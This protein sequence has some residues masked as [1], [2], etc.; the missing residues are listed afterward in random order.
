MAQAQQQDLIQLDIVDEKTVNLWRSIG[1][2][3]KTGGRSKM[4]R[5]RTSSS[6]VALMRSV[7][8]SVQ[9][10]KIDSRRSFFLPSTSL[11]PA[12]SL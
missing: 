10:P 12:A 6:G 4:S 7:T 9:C 11:P 5:L 1:T 8:M 3:L 2:H